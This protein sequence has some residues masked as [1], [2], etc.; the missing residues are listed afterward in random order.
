MA[1][2]KA[3]GLKTL[4]RLARFN[5]DEKRRMLTELQNREDQI[6]EEIRQGE[7]QLKT[8]QQVA[9][10]DAT[11][12]G[13]LYGAYHR[14][15]MA[16]REQQEIALMA[17]RHMIEGA[18]DELAEAFRQLKTYEITQRERERREQQEADRK[19][20]AF[21]DEMGQQMH[22]RKDMEG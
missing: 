7:A 15:W 1:A 14:A 2:A 8:E 5:V 3:K 6:L 18:R 10:E 21:L 9:A 19:E 17:V 4:I 11:G 20:Q 16:R 12:V 22:Q 13:F